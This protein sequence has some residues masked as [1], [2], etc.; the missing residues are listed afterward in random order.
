M[1]ERVLDP[2]MVLVGNGITFAFC[3]SNSYVTVLANTLSVVVHPMSS[4]PNAS[5]PFLMSNFAQKHHC[6]HIIQPPR[7][8]SPPTDLTTS[9]A[10][11]RGTGPP[12]PKLQ[13]DSCPPPPQKPV[14]TH[15]PS[16]VLSTSSSSHHSK[17]PHSTVPPSSQKPTT[18]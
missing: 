3:L 5:I 16:S 14:H 10:L 6:Q 7:C 9:P 4:H 15:P 1:C 2:K 17:S 8:L 18:H 11:P 12:K 13:Q